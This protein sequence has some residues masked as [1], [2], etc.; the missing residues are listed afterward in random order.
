MNNELMIPTISDMITRSDTPEYI[1]DTIKKIRN[2]IEYDI[3]VYN[4]LYLNNLIKEKDRKNNKNPIEI[5]FH[6]SYN[7]HT[8]SFF[9]R[10]I[11]QSDIDM[12][13][14][15]G[16]Y[17]SSPSIFKNR[18]QVDKNFNEFKDQWSSGIYNNFWF[19]NDD[20]GISYIP[21]SHFAKFKRDLT[22]YLIKTLKNNCEVQDSNKVIKI[23]TGNLTI[24]LAICGAFCLQLKNSFKGFELVKKIKKYFK[25]KESNGEYLFSEDNN[26]LTIYG[27]NVI[28]SDLKEIQN[29]PILNEKF[30]R[31]KN[32]ATDGWFSSYVRFFKNFIKFI[33]LN[34]EEKIPLSSFHIEC[35]LYNINDKFFLAL[36]S[37]NAKYYLKNIVL[38]ILNTSENDFKYIN[39]IN[40]LIRINKK[41]SYFDFK[42]SMLII[43]KYIKSY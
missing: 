38:E 34:T 26:S 11:E 22:N 25:D 2:I 21:I 14:K 29:F 17:Y 16:D 7:R 12:Y 36:N 9:F 1:K 6:G 35:I 18:N 39:E 20:G 4:L 10:K 8:G 43:Q 33:N 41:I 28:T 23:R 13:L 30:I 42:E 19:N 24:E 15:I 5:K 27:I 37:E 40:D 32:S 3:E 31:L